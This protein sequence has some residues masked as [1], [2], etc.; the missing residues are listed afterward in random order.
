MH[1]FQSRYGSRTDS[2]YGWERNVQYTLLNVYYTFDFTGMKCLLFASSFFMCA[3]AIEG[4][5]IENRFNFHTALNYAKGFAFLYLLVVVVSCFFVKQQQTSNHKY[6]NFCCLQTL[7]EMAEAL[8]LHRL[9]VWLVYAVRCTHSC[10]FLLI[11]ECYGVSCVFFLLQ[12]ILFSCH[13]HCF[14]ATER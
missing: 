3:R 5:E 13:T 2:S 9:C 10:R 1:S 11:A 8:M 12:P 14:I 6:F 4:D 7:S